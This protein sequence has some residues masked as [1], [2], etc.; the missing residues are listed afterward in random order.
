MMSQ[1]LSR[2]LSIDPTHPSLPGHFPGLPVVPGVVFL[3][4]IL[5]ELAR[6]IPAAQVIG[7][8][9]LKFLRMLLPQHGFTV[10]FAAPESNSLRFKCWRSADDL[11]ANA[12]LGEAAVRE[13]LVEG[14]L[15]LRDV[16]MIAQDH[17]LP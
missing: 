17:V 4:Y 9:K 1:V 2:P 14:H 8:R 16:A 10:E 5:T 3:S 15:L 6:Q 7:I 11:S 13:L 12:Q